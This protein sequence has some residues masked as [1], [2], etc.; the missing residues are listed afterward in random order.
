MDTNLSRL[1]NKNVLIVGDIG[2]DKY[3]MGVVDRVSPEAP[4]PV[5]LVKEEYYRLGMASNVANNIRT[6]GAT[7]FLVGA[8]GNDSYAK[9]FLQTLADNH[10]STAHILTVDGRRTTVKERI[11]TTQQQIV[12]VDYEETTPVPQNILRDS[13]EA[14]M[15]TVDIVIV[16]DYA[17]GLLDSKLI[18]FVVATAKSFGKL[19]LADPHIKSKAENYKGCSVLTPNRKEL[20]ALT[21]VSPTNKHTM[22]EAIHRL[23]DKTLCDTIVVTL[24]EDGMAIYSNYEL[25]TIPTVARQVY[26]VSGAGDTVISTLAIALASGLNIYEA[27]TLGNYAAGV[28]VGKRGTSITTKDEIEEFIVGLR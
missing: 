21:G 13:I 12:R 23:E 27:C 15:L 17:K 7:P 25:R 16:Q 26:D 4:V 1:T 2:L 20:E 28:V 22:L 9:A 24:G 5:L 18:K 8:I 14:L 11:L 10:V 6:L 19:V 3:T